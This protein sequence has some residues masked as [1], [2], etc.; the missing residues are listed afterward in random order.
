MQLQDHIRLLRDLFSLV[1]KTNKYGDHAAFLGSLF[2]SLIVLEVFPLIILSLKCSYFNL[3]LFH[4]SIMHCCEEPACVLLRRFS[5]GMLLSPAFEA[6]SSPGLISQVPS[7]SPHRENVPALNISAWPLLNLLLFI[8]VWRWW[9]QK[10]LTIYSSWFTE[11]ILCS[12]FSTFVVQKCCNSEFSY[13]K[14]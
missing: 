1:M 6:L 3:W 11:T 8:E 10:F 14:N 2:H 12:S 9:A 7:A 5:G 13:C 4:A